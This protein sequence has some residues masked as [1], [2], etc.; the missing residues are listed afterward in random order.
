MHARYLSIVAFFFLGAWIVTTFILKRDYSK[1]LLDLISKNMLDLKSF[2]EEDV[3]H[4]FLDKKNR[5]NSILH[6]CNL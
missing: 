2:D 1:I 4:I 3:N 6:Y 5:L